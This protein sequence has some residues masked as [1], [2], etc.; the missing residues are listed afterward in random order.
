MR[1]RYRFTVLL[2]VGLL[3]AL[4]ASSG[5]DA[6]PATSPAI[7]VVALYP[8]ASAEVVEEAI[9]APLDVTLFGL[10]G[11]ES[12]HARSSDGVSIVTLMFKPGTDLTKARQTVEN[13]LKSARPALP[14]SATVATER[15]W[16]DRLPLLWLVLSSRTT[17]LD[18]LSDIAEKKLRPAVADLPGVGALAVL[19]ARQPFVR[20]NFK[21]ANLDLH[22]LSVADLAWALERK[23]GER[24][25]K[26]GRPE[27][28]KQLENVLLRKSRRR[29]VFLRDV[30]SV[31]VSGKAS[32]TAR[33]NGQGVVALSVAPAGED[34]RTTFAQIEKALPRLRKSLPE[35][36]QL[37]L[38]GSAPKE[39]K[40][41]HAFWADVRIPPGAKKE[42]PEERL[43]KVEGK[44]R[45]GKGVLGVLTT[46]AAPVTGG[47]LEASLYV[48]LEAGAKV[49]P[50]VDQ[51]R[52]ALGDHPD[53]QARALD[54]SA[55]GIPPLRRYPIALVLAG[56]DRAKVRKWSAGLAKR[57]REDKNLRDVF[58]EDEGD[59]S[60]VYM[61][62][63]RKAVREEGLSM[64]DV[65]TTLQIMTGGVRTGEIV[66]RGQRY[67]VMLTSG[68]SADPPSAKDL[69]A[70]K[71]RSAA[72]RMVPFDK[73]A[74]V[75]NVR[76]ALAL[77][78][79]NGQPAVEITASPGPKITAARALGR[80]RGHADAVRRA[81]DLPATYR[82]IVRPASSAK[83]PS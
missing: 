59:V 47:P 79:Y 55:Q 51:F 5:A 80:C 22:G 66:V 76:H 77:V 67:E 45:A 46:I 13:R 75:R 7:R 31:E 19:G 2:A 21:Q 73:I 27:S 12:A 10:P 32:S 74:T 56:P 6:P 61:D 14:A 15:A 26:G 37:R 62:V 57:L 18:G 36:A 35:G 81:L 28:F 16:P 78:R 20:I 70:L 64:G 69:A 43:G 49:G 52:A 83:G 29:L 82:V 17:S 48:Q 9:T 71:L 39:G 40:G 63:N 23:I 24:A 38:V 3:G 30:A 60:S 4:S 72:G 58:A 54:L 44:V 53:L 1:S 65:V 11:V 42:Q 34:G 33:W 68:G 8:G 41:P 50:A 25:P